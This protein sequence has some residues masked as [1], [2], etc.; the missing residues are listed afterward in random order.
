M[1]MNDA[2][3][4][5]S[6]PRFTDSDLATPRMSAVHVL[7]RFPL[8]ITLT[9]TEKFI[10]QNWR[11]EVK[12]IAV[13]A[14]GSIIT[15]LLAAY[16]LLRAT[17]QREK[18]IALINDL[19]IQLPG[20]L[21]QYQQSSDGST[22][23]PYVN[24]GFLD[25]YGLDA[26]HLP[27]EGSM[28]FS[29]LHPEDKERIQTSI[30]ESILNLQ[31]WHEDYR[32]IL[33]DTRLVWLHG[34]AQPQ[35]LAD[36]S[37][38]L[39]GYIADITRSKLIEQA[40]Q[41]ESEKNRALL[42]NASDGIHI[43]DSNGYIIDISDSFCTMLGY[44]REEMIGMHISQWD[45]CKTRTEITNE[46]RHQLTQRSR[47]QFE[48]QHR[49]SDGSI[50]DVE[51]S[52]LTIEL[53]GQRVIFSSSRDI[54]ERKLQQQ[55]IEQEKLKAESAN[56][57][58]SNFLAN[59]SHEIRTPMNA[60]IGLSDLALQSSDQHE[61]VGYLRQI[62]DSS[63]LLLGILND[64]L[65]F[66]KI[67]AGQ[68][69]LE[70][71]V[72]NIDLLNDSLD[73]LFNKIAKDKNIGFSLHK[74]IRL[75]NLLIGDELRIRQILTNL[76]GN[77]LKFT[78]NGTVFLESRLIQS[79]DSKVTIDFRVQDTGIG[80]SDEQIAKLFKPFVQA[81]N[82][83]TRRFGGT[84]LG[85][86]ISRNLAQMMGGDILVESTLGS[87][88]LFTFHVT[89]ELANDSQK[90]EY[91]KRY[92]TEKSP[93]KYSDAAQ[94]LQGKRILLVEDNR[95]NQLVATQMLKKLSVVIDVANNGAESLQR[96]ENAS[97]DI[98][99]MDVQMPVMD[100]LEA[101][102]LIRQN[103]KYK[104][105]PIIA[106]SAGVTLDEQAECSTAGMTHFIGKPADFKQLTNMM[107]ELCSTQPEQ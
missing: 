76:L 101:T 90:D 36:H 50:F 40:L 56:R 81:D 65:D 31:P 37:V 42:L 19:T 99:L 24:K 18:N 27:L 34:D 2:V 52:V 33:P 17:S 29:Y 13:V 47:S 1:K 20:M 96:L 68:I 80:I 85:L 75:P 63:K 89:L 39:H 8:I 72:F 87:G 103:P 4:Q 95:M 97:Y 82:S 38:L 54:T 23:L 55:I 30:Q 45:A 22:S 49:R 92:K 53:Q 59:M 88:T 84:G 26:Q 35:T 32:L 66:S 79:N 105:L 98:V 102:R 51:L 14:T 74:D 64:I 107:I 61:Q 69:S 5:N 100:G 71:Q 67:E 86:S 25:T 93:S 62:L 106:M 3:I 7:D 46:I 21:F 83:T 43:I 48:T 12:S 10:L 78:E 57:A 28:L 41:R 94:I 44:Q 9:V 16:F 70:R 91:N 11:N 6:S 58:K 15:L 77:A 60:V 73:R 104:T